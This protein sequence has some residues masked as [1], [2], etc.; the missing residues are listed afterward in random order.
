MKKF[1]VYIFLFLFLYLFLLEFV[2]RI[3][4]LS[5]HTIPEANLNNDKLC[6]PYSEDTWVKGGMHEIASHYKINSQ[7]FN[8]LKDYSKLDKTKVSIAIIGDSYVQ[9][10]HSDV[11]KSIGRLL[12]AETDNKVEV[13]EYGKAGGNIVD[14]SLLFEKFIRN[15]YDYTFILITN[16]D[17]TASKASFMTKGSS[18]PKQS[19]VREIYSKSSF[20]RYLNINHG[21]FFKFKKISSCPNIKGHQQQKITK[22]DINFSALNVFDSRC[23]FIYEENKLDTSLIKSMINNPLVKINHQIKPYDH[24]FDS[25]WNDSGRINCALSIKNH[26]KTK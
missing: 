1:I 19:L 15:R 4:S 26:I 9:G 24:G 23:I 22:K 8:S 13:H 10:L 3:F 14:F 18:V 7:G 6:A 12:E 21:L 2:T 25:H 16:K 17:I 20:V 11:E 5:G